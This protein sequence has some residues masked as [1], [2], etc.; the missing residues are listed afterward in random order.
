VRQGVVAAHARDQDQ[1]VERTKHAIQVT[2]RSG[3][4]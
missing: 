4:G 2:Q 3:D 1:P